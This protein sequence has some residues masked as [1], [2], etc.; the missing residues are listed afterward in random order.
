MKKISQFF[1]LILVCFTQLFAIQHHQINEEAIRHLANEF[2]LTD[3]D[4][5]NATQKNWL[6]KPNQERWDMQELTLNQREIVIRWAESHGLFREGFPSKKTYDQA[7]IFGAATPAMQKRLEY[8]IQLWNDGIR[9]DQ[10]TWLTGERPLDPKVDDCLNECKTEAD[11]AKVIWERAS[12]PE[13]MRFLKVV[14]IATPPQKQRDSFRKA[15]T[16][17]TLVN[18]LECYPSHC[19]VFFVSNQP[20]CL[21]QSAVANSVIPDE[22]TFEVVGPSANPNGHHAMA[23]V[24]LD[25]LARFLYEEAARQPK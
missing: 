17:D 12:L 24:V 25:T 14:F 19:S 7:I 20:F 21:Y 5:L 6:R 15:N 4:L 13:E 11:A 18:W 10:I 16:Q 8:L 23:A 22:Y 3:S 2:G 9:F 1:I